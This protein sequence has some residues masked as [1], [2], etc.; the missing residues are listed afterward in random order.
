VS[1]AKLRWTMLR[2][3]LKKNGAAVFR[4]G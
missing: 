3:L 2:N 4:D 1:V